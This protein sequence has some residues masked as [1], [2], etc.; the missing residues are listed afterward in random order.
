MFDIRILVDWLGGVLDIMEVC[1]PGS[2][3]D[4]RKEDILGM[5]EVCKR[6]SSSCYNALALSRNANMWDIGHG[7]NIPCGEYPVLDSVPSKVGAKVIILNP[8]LQLDYNDEVYLYNKYGYYDGNVL[9]VGHPYIDFKEL[10]NCVL[11][12]QNIFVSKVPTSKV[13]FDGESLEGVVKGAFNTIQVLSKGCGLMYGIEMDCSHPALFRYR[14]IP[15]LYGNSKYRYKSGSG[16]LD[17]AIVELVR[18]TERVSKKFGVDLSGVY[19][20]KSLINK[21]SCNARVIY[22]CSTKEYTMLVY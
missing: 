11:Q 18:F 3:V 10:D 7:G 5:M 14:C 9:T 13:V 17:D 16:R 21:V 4:I 19:W 20:F 8:S 2:L 15:V 1:K 22:S 6:N 12:F